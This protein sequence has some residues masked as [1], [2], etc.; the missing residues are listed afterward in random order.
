[1]TI[2]DKSRGM[3]SSECKSHWTFRSYP[4]HDFMSV[5]ASL[6]KM[7]FIKYLKVVLYQMTSLHFFD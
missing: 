1:M 5:F 7:G 4:S 3:N 2:A 6:K